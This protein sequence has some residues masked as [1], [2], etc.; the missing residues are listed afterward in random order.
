[1]I[2]NFNSTFIIKNKKPKICNKVE[3]MPIIYLWKVNEKQIKYLYI[4]HMHFIY[5]ISWDSI[6]KKKIHQ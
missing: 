2:K 6:N 3:L 5:N 4:L 1:M